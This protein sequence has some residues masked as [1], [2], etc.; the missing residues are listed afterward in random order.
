MSSSLE[1]PK[2]AIL[3]DGP[4]MYDLN[5]Y[6]T[7]DGKMFK[8]HPTTGRVKELKFIAKKGCFSWDNA[9]KL[10]V[11]GTV[12][13]ME[14]IDA[15]YCSNKGGGFANRRSL[16]A[17]YFVKKLADP[18]GMR[19]V[20]I[21]SDQPVHAKN[22]RWVQAEEQI[23]ERMADLRL[24]VD[25]ENIFRVAENVNLEQDFTEWQY[26][27]W[28]KNDGSRVVRIHEN[29]TIRENTISTG[30]DGYQN[31]NMY[32]DGKRINFRMNRLMAMIH[33]GDIEGGVVD[34]IN[35]DISDNRPEN[36][37][38]VSQEEN[39]RRGNVATPIIKVDPISM[40]VVEEIRSI[41]E[42]IDSNPELV[43]KSLH[44]A[45]AIGDLYAGFRWFDTSLEGSLYNIADGVVEFMSQDDA[46]KIIRDRI[47][48]MIESNT[49][50]KD[51]IPLNGNEP[52][53]TPEIISIVQKLDPR[54][55]G[56]TPMLQQTN[57]DIKGLLPCCRLISYHGAVSNSQLVICLKTLLIFKRSRDNLINTE[58][59]PCPFCV[60][61][62][63]EDSSRYTFGYEDPWATIPVYTYNR[64]CKSKKNPEPL[65]F[66]KKYLTAGD[67]LEP[68]DKITA[69]RTLSAVQ[70]LR[71]SLFQCSS[72][73]LAKT[74]I[75]KRAKCKIVY[76][77]FYPP[78]NG[79]M[80][81]ENPSW[82]LQRRLSCAL[83]KFM[84]EYYQPIYSEKREN[85]NTK[86]RTKKDADEGL[87]K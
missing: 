14:P 13:N 26:G 27:Y 81:E 31:I 23:A 47:D 16:L 73:F 36:L 28:I 11:D 79:F 52:I 43:H 3:C 87:A 66:I 56:K 54:D 34:H 8:T 15:F 60:F 71:Y 63:S 12:S 37:D 39:I 42:Y 7:P 50:N 45:K 55:I 86:D 48:K 1:I 51:I 70:S 57:N 62:R 40:K 78:K 75:P 2:D 29:G 10:N 30:S 33:H 49:I 72:G 84:H 77:S 58:R 61:D 80:S 24:R 19:T 53:H 76:V 5:R 6:I 21:N 67:I 41:Q 22:L 74:N 64:G 20:L 17:Y 32:I 82:I 25:Y 59:R 18:T 69:A 35:G 68:E 85:Q 65:K 46:L 38:I 83:I 44:R 9:K 4:L